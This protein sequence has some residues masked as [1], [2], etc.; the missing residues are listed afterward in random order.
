MINLYLRRFI[1]FFSIF[2]FLIGAPLLS[3]YAVGYRYDFK[4]REIVKVG[5]I[6][7]EI[8]P[9]NSFL[10]IEKK[11]FS[12]GKNFQKEIFPGEYNLRIEKEAHS[13]WQKRVEIFSQKITD[14]GR[15]RLFLEK[16][17]I[18]SVGLRE[19]LDSF[20]SSFDSQKIAFLD[21]RGKEFSLKLFD[22]SQKEVKD[23]FSTKSESL[24]KIFY[25]FS[26]DD[27]K[28]FIA[29]QDENLEP[30][31]VVFNL[32]D[33][34]KRTLIDNPTNQLEKIK[35]HPSDS[36]R[37]FILNQN[38]LL[39]IEAKKGEVKVFFEGKIIDYSLEEK[40]IF[41][42]EEIEEK[43]FLS[44]MKFDG[45]RKEKLVEL[46]NKN[47][48]ILPQGEKVALIDLENN[49][50]FLLEEGKLEKIDEKVE[51]LFWQNEEKLFYQ[52][53]NQV[54]QYDL[55]EKEKKLIFYPKEKI[56]NIVYSPDLDYILISLEN[57]IEI[58]ELKGGN[59]FTVFKGG[60]ENL[61]AVFDREGEGVFFVDKR[62]LFKAIIH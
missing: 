42:I 10:F 24:E 6:K 35:W 62:K 28:I 43:Y 59:S 15:V 57:R 22:L 58:L 41:F 46:K 30:Q 47:F 61:E 52:K 34:Q 51:K 33:L 29:F 14:L 38:N 48:E 50:A 3:F 11:K 9:R 1:L 4:K 21:F 39:Q 27:Q 53:E 7:I 55:E 16:P 13:S 12:I 19:N 60:I 37:L 23:L 44:K 49:Q 31:L 18:F 20:R 5:L 32:K 26:Y 56:K 36:D 17:K 45:S 25:Q 8:E 54:W 40:D 2:I